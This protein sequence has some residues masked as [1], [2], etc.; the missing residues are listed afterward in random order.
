MG[1]KALSPKLMHIFVQITRL[2]AQLQESPDSVVI[3]MGAAKIQEMLETFRQ[4]LQLSEGYASVLELLESCQLGD[5]GKVS[6]PTKVTELSGESSRTPVRASRDPVTGKPR[7]HPDVRS[8]LDM[9]RRCFQPLPESGPLLTAQTPFFPVFLMAIVSYTEEDRAVAREWFETALSHGGRSSI[10]SVWHAT[11]LLWAW[12]DASAA[13][14]DSVPFDE[15][16]PVGHR[17]AW[18]EDMVEYLM[19]EV[20]WISLT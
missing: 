11:K 10:P 12:L 5:D 16:T 13:A 7:S 3:P 18:W 6:S 19:Q 20:G 4:R 14:E 8:T 15:D 9:L 17:Y 2:C 1:R